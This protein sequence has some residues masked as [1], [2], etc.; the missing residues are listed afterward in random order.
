MSMPRKRDGKTGRLLTYT[1]EDFFARIDKSVSAHGCWPWIGYVD[2]YGYGDVRVSGK[3]WKSHRLAFFI[4][5]G[6]SP[7]SVCHRC[8]NPPCCNPAHLFA[9]DDAINQADCRAKDRNARGSRNGHA[10]LNEEIVLKVLNTPKYRGVGVDLARELNISKSVITQ[11]RKRQ[12]WRH[13]QAG[14]SYG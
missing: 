9:G 5:T 8:D 2:D 1:H 10:K 6:L 7:H 13:V 14:E 11:I 3:R 4:A 12:I